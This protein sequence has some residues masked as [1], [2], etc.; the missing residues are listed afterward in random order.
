MVAAFMPT[1]HSA[2]PARLCCMLSNFIGIH[3]TPRA[4]RIVMSRMFFISKYDK[5]FRTIITSVLI[6]VVNMLMR[7][8]R[9]SQHFFCNNAVFKDVSIFT[10]RMVVRT[11]DMNVP[12]V[13]YELPTFPPAILFRFIK[14]PI[15]SVHKVS[16]TSDKLS[17]FWDKAC[18]YARGLTT[19]THAHSRWSFPTFGWVCSALSFLS[20]SKALYSKT[21]LHLQEVLQDISRRVMVVVG[22]RWDYFAT[23]TLTDELHYNLLYVHDTGVR[24]QI[25]RQGGT[26]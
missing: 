4:Q 10:R 17:Q 14:T 8:N 2:L 15:M 11:I 7:L 1:N 5:V 13:V 24:W 23:T 20:L 12:I 26:I 16:V 6:L 25:Q 21:I 19:T 18:R 9:T 3:F 22:F